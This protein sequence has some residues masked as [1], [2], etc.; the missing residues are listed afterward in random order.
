MIYEDDRVEPHR[1]RAKSVQLAEKGK[2]AW[3]PR[4]S[5]RTLTRD[6]I[7]LSCRSGNDFNGI[8]SP[9]YTETSAALT[10]R[11]MSQS[12]AILSSVSVAKRRSVRWHVRRYTKAGTL[13]SAAQGL[14]EGNPE[15]AQHGYCPSS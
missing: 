10:L 7:A 8:I 2:P 5:K 12:Q 1:L 13:H 6:Y 4:P 9:Y 14:C 15:A 11:S 3:A